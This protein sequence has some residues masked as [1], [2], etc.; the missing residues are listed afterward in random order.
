MLIQQA[1]ASCEAIKYKDVALREQ[2]AHGG[3]QE[4]QP[5][6]VHRR[7]LPMDAV[8]QLPSGPGNL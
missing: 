8:S 7:F 5:V 3:G 4:G 6:A 1:D 2:L